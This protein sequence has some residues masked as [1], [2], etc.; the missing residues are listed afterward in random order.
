MYTFIAISFSLCASMPSLVSYPV[1]RLSQDNTLILLFK[2]HL[3]FLEINNFRTR[4]DVLSMTK[5]EN[6]LYTQM[7]QDI[8]RKIWQESVHKIFSM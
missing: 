3:L 7:G 5:M 4:M 1:L 6:P 2:Y 8:F